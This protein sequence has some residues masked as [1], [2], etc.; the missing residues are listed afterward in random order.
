MEP[1]IADLINKPKIP[2]LIRCLFVAV[3]CASICFIGILCGVQSRAVFGIIFG[4][5]L[6]LGAAAPAGYLLKRICRSKKQ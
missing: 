3:D 5:A 1:L 6:A 2:K 4:A